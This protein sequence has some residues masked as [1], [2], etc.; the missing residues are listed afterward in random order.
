MERQEFREVQ[1]A[2]MA[3]MVAAMEAVREAQLYGGAQGV[4]IKAADETLV[5]V[6]DKKVEVIICQ[7]LAQSLPDIP[8]LAEEGTSDCEASHALRIL[9]DPL[10]GTRAFSVGLATSTVIIAAIDQVSQHVVLCMVG[11]PATGRIWS[12]TAD[13]RTELQIWN[14]VALSPARPV[15]VWQG[16]LS[17]QAT[18]LM[19]VSH[20]FKKEGRHILSTAQVQVLMCRVASET[21]L[22][23]PGSNGLHLALMANGGTGLAAQIT[24]AV[25]GPWDI[26]GVLLVQKAGGYAR[27]FRAES[28]V[29]TEVDALRITACD[30]LVTGNNPETVDHLVCMLQDVM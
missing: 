1:E 15:Q 16:A 28:G 9:V 3:A 20:G 30:I 17:Q 18:V 14:G 2:I 21:K 24:T 13:T 25:G 19:D 12:A 10:D 27:G 6:T 8:I 7:C 29:L 23:M 22:L 26:A 4:G 11:E 5:T